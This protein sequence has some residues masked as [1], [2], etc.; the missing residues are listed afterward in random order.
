MIN[1]GFLETAKR[2]TAPEKREVLA[3]LLAEQSDEE[4]G[5]I[6]KSFRFGNDLR[7]VAYNPE[8]EQFVAELT[9]LLQKGALARLENQSDGT[10]EIYGEQRTFYVTLSER[11]GFVALLSSWLPTNPPKEINLTEIS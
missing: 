5:T 6:W 4:I 9:S 1:E 2:L 10:Y 3:R 11:K 7:V 8:Q